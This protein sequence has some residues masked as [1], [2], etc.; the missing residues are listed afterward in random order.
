MKSLPI[1]TFLSYTNFW[2][3]LSSTQSEVTIGLPI[4]DGASTQ[5]MLLTIDPSSPTVKCW[6]PPWLWQGVN[7]TGPNISQMSRQRKDSAS[8]IFKKKGVK[9]YSILIRVLHITVPKY[10]VLSLSNC[11]SGNTFSR[12]QLKS[13]HWRRFLISILF[14]KS[15]WSA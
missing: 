5:P 12:Y 14:V 7:L 13:L 15:P 6:F 8:R 2:F 4:S 10:A 3:N 11:I 1:C 9:Y